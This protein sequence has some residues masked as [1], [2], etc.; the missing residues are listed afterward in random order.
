MTEESIIKSYN[1]GINAVISLIKDLNYDFVNQMRSLTSE[2]NTLNSEM[3]ALKARIAELEARLNKNSNNSSKPPSTD[4]YKKTI[5]NNRVKSGRHTGGQYGHEGHTLLKVENPDHTVDAPIEDHCDCGANLSEVDDIIRTRQEF[6]LPEIKPIVTE[7]RTH[8]KI[9]PQCGKVHKSEFPTHISQPTQYGV[10]MKGIMTYLTDYQFIPLK[11]AVETIEEIIGQTV[12]Q[13]TLVT[14]SEKLYEILEKPVEAIKQ[15]IKK[16]KVVHFDETGIRSEGKTKWI[17]VASTETLT[18]YEMHEKRGTDAAVDIDILPKFNGTAVHDHWKTY[19]T[20]KECTHSECNSHN[21]RYLK[22]IYE[23]F[24]HAWAKAMAGFLIELKNQVEAMKTEGLTGMEATQ[25]EAWMTIFHSIIKEGIK[26][27]DERSL[28]VFSKKTGKLLR[29][30][31]LNLLLKMQKYDIETLAFMYDFDIPFDNNL[32]ERDLRMQ[33]LRQK[34]SGC[35]RGKEG[36][37]VFCR[38]RS[39]ISTAR[40]NGQKVMESLV[41]AFKGK[42]FLPET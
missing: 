8:E 42:P 21:L 35:F 7:Y 3:I 6:E 24:D 19:Y 34:I 38:I 16:S 33:K 4:G 26:E 36:A 11:R 40:K 29:T 9:C 37:N 12:S 17:H 2:I 20:F 18:Y 30:K 15:Q 39:Y 10:K 5:K 31:A 14:A 23:N 32:A 1:E 41:N 27:D 28:K 13:G 25:S 22:E